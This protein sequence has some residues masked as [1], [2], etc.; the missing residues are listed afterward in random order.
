MEAQ[1]L[2]VNSRVNVIAEGERHL[3]VV[4]RSTEFR[5]EYVNNLV[6][7]WENQIVTLSTIA[8]TQPPAAYLAFTSGFKVL[9]ENH[10]KRQPLTAT[11]RKNN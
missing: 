1:N 9:P 11:Y 7:Y 6:K 10:S 2:F 8:K 3:S 5:D 4:I